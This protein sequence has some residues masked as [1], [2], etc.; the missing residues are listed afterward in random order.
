M[1]VMSAAV[2]FDLAG[3]GLVESAEDMQKRA[4]AGAACADN[5]DKLPCPDGQIN[6]LEHLKIDSTHAVLFVNILRS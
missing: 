4:L 6:A 1:A 2:K 5:G 3:V